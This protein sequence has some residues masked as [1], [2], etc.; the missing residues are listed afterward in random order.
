MPIIKFSETDITKA[1][2]LNSLI[3]S[4]LNLISVVTH[5]VIEDDFPH[6]SKGIRYVLTFIITLI[7][8]LIIFILF[9]I[10]FGFGE[11]LISK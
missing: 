11:S 8:G 9:R 5:D 4:I 6:I 3:I 7:S 10:T 1:I 2:I